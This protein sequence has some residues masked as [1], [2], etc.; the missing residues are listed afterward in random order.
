MAF[1]FLDMLL[2]TDSDGMHIARRC[3]SKTGSLFAVQT[4]GS[5]SWFV[6]GSDNRNGIDQTLRLLSGFSAGIYSPEESSE[7][8]RCCPE[9]VATTLPIG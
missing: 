4:A 9:Q 1:W 6:S 7:T 2:C 8:R 3:K 5:K